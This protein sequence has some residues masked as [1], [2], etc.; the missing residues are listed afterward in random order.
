MT[1]LAGLFVPVL[2]LFHLVGPVPPELGIHGNQLSPCSSP[3][4]CSRQTWP[5]PDPRSSFAALKAFVADMPRTVLVEQNDGYL[6][7]EVSS[8]LFGFV[9]D[10]EL[11][12]PTP[13]A[14]RT[15]LSPDCDSD[16]GVNAASAQPAWRWW[17]PETTQTFVF[18]KLQVVGHVPQT[19]QKTNG[20]HR[21]DAHDDHRL[22]QS[23]GVG[24]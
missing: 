1:L 10:L 9:D 4:H 19:G 3:A 13:A 12:I 21:H 14:I 18:L 6:H 8:A 2:M 16:L 23:V 17:R 11:L 20:G 7:A 22:Q 24:Q 15:E 5:S